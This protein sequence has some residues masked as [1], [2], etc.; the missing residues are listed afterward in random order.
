MPTEDQRS[1][2]QHQVA[3]QG[4]LALM[5]PLKILATTLGAA[6]L[7]LGL[8]FAYASSP[9][10]AAIIT[11]NSLADDADGTDGECTLREA[12]TSANTDTAS[13]PATGECAPG[14]GGDEIHF[15]L[16][17][18]APWTVNL[19]GELPHLTTN[20]ELEGPGAD[21]LT[22][23]RDTGGDYRIFTV[24][25]S[26]TVATISG[27]TISNG[28]APAGNAG[29]GISKEQGDL[30]VTNSTI[31]GNSASAGGGISNFQGDLT[32][33]NSTISGNFATVTGGN[34]GGG[35]FSSTDR[36]GVTTITNSTISGNT[37]ATYGGGVYN[38]GGPT[39]IE[40]STIT[41]NFAQDGLG[42]GVA[43][44]G[45]TSTRTEVLSSIISANQGTDVD[46]VF[47]PTNSFVSEGYNLIGSGN[48]T[49][50][51]N[52]PGDQVGKD[53]KLGALA[54][55]GGPTQTHALLSGSPAIDAGP[56]T[57][58]DPIACPPPD[59]DQRG[60]S[61]PQ[62]STCDIGAF[63][64]QA[65][66]PALS[67]DDITLTEADSGT[68]AAAFTVSLSK[69]SSQTVTVDYAT[70]DGTATAGADYQTT[71]GTL[72]F[73]P[74]ETSKIVT[75][76]VIDDIV[77]EPDETFLVNL[78]NPTNATISDAQGTGTI[79]DD[80]PPP[81]TTA[82]TTTIVLTPTSPN[83]QN[84]WYTSAVHLTVGATDGTGGSGVAETR[85]VLDPASAP[86]SFDDLPTSPCPYLGSGADVSAAGQHILY[87]ASSD[88]E[89]N[90]ETPLVS[91]QFKIDTQAPT[92]TSTFPR[93]GGEVGP[94]ANIRATF[95]EDMQEASVIAAFKLFRKGSTTRI[96]ATVT[97]D[98][99][100]DTATLNPTNNLRRGATYKAV[101]TTAAKDLAGN[102]L[103]QNSS[104]SGLQQKV[105]FFEIDN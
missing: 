30:T 63:E 10:W 38:S 13:G 7:V 75:V 87:A 34:L 12:I 54:E 57:D 78:S 84:G 51:F 56:P 96:A 103:D 83:G 72:T 60:V 47:L 16:P 69:A 43:S 85:C 70:A 55:N 100:T 49:G 81:D 27:I 3:P 95:S 91:R 93:G 19:T 102:R 105:W 77:D 74:G 52:Q 31:S 6:L 86:T 98:A 89:G 66:Q 5:P 71:R 58:G 1:D 17:G 29:G 88:E 37:S 90:E 22:V 76:P 48:A 8:L 99:E 39:V 35:I 104:K 14:S 28:N 101:V 26:T 79:T 21:Q 9:A 15:A 64:L 20:I 41:N 73:A 82:P 24:R 4:V 42:Y 44:V 80:D 32:V 68:T 50:A 92:V 11:V 45:N 18:T 61:R 53:P 97:Y 25:V 40:F 59:T 65:S 46:F 33:T 23:R 2:R 36:R 62:G 94:A 67:I